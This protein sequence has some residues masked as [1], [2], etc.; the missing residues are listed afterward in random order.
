MSPR[1]QTGRLNAVELQEALMNNDY[2]KF[3]MHVIIAMIDMFDDDK[4]KEINFEEFQKI[5]AFLGNWREVFNQF[6]V[7]K[8]G[9]IDAD[10]LTSGKIRICS[11]G[12]SNL[13]FS[14]KTAWIQ[15]VKTFY[16]R[17]D[18]KIRL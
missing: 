7:D 5:W 4:T 11:E 3:D 17:F 13:C 8:G 2:T 18:G 9:A 16:Q 1:S 6:D 10:E 15:L 14:Y 12:A